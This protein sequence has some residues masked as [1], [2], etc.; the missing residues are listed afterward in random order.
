[1]VRR[2]ET[3]GPRSTR[4][5]WTGDVCY[6]SRVVL[7]AG[8]CSNSGR[9]ASAPLPPFVVWIRVTWHRLEDWAD[10]ENPRRRLGATGACH[11]LAFLDARHVRPGCLLRI[12][13]GRQC[14]RAMTLSGLL[15]CRMHCSSVPVSPATES[16][17]WPPLAPRRRSFL[18]FGSRMP[19]GA[20]RPLAWGPSTWWFRLQ[21]DEPP[22]VRAVD[23]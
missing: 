20:W 4:F 7:G 9:A 16:L 15:A 12:S 19:R 22:S 17:S 11:L 14:C 5:E 21:K 2:T 8:W 6:G 23:T 13:G 18:H 1:M 10:T 3:V